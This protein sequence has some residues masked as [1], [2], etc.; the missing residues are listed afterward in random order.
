MDVGYD[1]VN[2]ARARALLHGKQLRPLPRA[3][4]DL[5]GSARGRGAARPRRRRTTDSHGPTAAG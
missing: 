2:L 5:A 4:F 3:A 1:R